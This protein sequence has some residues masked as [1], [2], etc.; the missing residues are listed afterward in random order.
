MPEFGEQRASYQLHNMA[1]YLA[2]GMR[3]VDVA[4]WFG[5]Y[6]RVDLSK[7]GY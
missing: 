1:C 4:S 5:T 2:R 3:Q 7:A 6:V